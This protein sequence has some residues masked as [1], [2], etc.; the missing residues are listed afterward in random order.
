MNIIRAK[1]SSRLV[2]S[3]AILVF[4]VL[5]VRVF[6]H[7]NSR[8]WAAY[9]REF[10]KLSEQKLL[11]QIAA[12]AQAGDSAET[13][14]WEKQLREARSM[15]PHLRQVFLPDANVRDLC[16]SCHLGIDNPLFADAPE[17]FKAHPGKMLDLH[18][19]D[20]FGC[21]V[22]HHGQGVGT[23]AFAAHGYEETWYNPLIPHQ[24]L[25]APCIGCHET[26]YGLEGAEQFE[27]G[28]LAFQKYGCY[29]C[30]SA[31]GFEDLPKF[32]PILDG[33]KEKL[34]D[35]RWMLSWL[36]TPEKMR[37]RTLM[38]TFTLSDD[39]IRDIAAYALSLK[40]DKEYP[41]VDLSPAS[42]KEGETLFTDLGCKACH[43][44]KREEDSLT[45]RIPNLSDAGI[46][47]NGNWV[48]EYLKDPKAYNPDTRMPKLDITDSDRL[49][50]TA[51]L[52]TLKDNAEL[53]RS[54][55][56]KTDGASVEN[57]GKLVQ[58]Q[59][60]YGCHKMKD[61]DRSPLPGVEVAE[62]AKKTLDELP[63]GN[64]QVPT[65][66]W[67]WILNK[68][69]EPK[70]YE[71]V[72]MPLKMPKFNFEEGE[73]E[74]LTIFY[75][76]NTV[77][78]L[79]Q[80]YMLAAAEAQRRG[81]AGEW[82]VTENHCRGCHMFEENV[83]PRID[84]FIGLKTYVPPRLV[85]EG[86]KVQPQWAFQY[87][88][89]PVPMRPWLKM[90]MPTF[91]F[92]Y[93][94]VQDMIDYFSVKSSSAEDARVP[95]VLIPQKEEMPQLDRDMG[96]YRVVA[97]KCMQCHPISLE[98]GLP[99]DVKLEDLSINLMLSKTRL[100]F[101]WIKNFLRNPDKYAGAGTK[102]PYV[103]YTPEGAQRV[104]DAEMW[105]D[106][107]SKYLMI[108][109]KIPE[110]PPEAEEEQKEEIDWTQMDY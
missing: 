2:F 107:V 3:A 72:D 66:K 32:A 92:S 79:P 99:E 23:T 40:S 82:E 33:F 94:Q 91:S 41:K 102:M 46:K 83:K 89:K 16:T 49:N 105:I 74:S 42:A 29:D 109:D 4:A 108:M 26:S 57:G 85:G 48:F 61:F 73:I 76:S 63:F 11:E 13:E 59:G 39:E 101:E 110:K 7:E 15:R 78:Q 9:Q 55:P 14:K 81:Q 1:F 93:E 62:V 44:E 12:S 28:R 50:L 53:V 80:K 25:Q 65:T 106:L 30:H 84:Q 70:I 10:Q 38:P 45:R 56:L 58:L 6:Q 22:C 60:C 103:Y 8:E 97:D 87:L 96:E 17:P 5:T 36:K 69:K 52:M 86:E 37:P 77:F 104:S 100:R 20:K 98:G 75:F 54:E 64:S 67:D 31:R 19:A 95:Y 51:Y 24:Y 34:A 18:K 71:T 47:L 68:I 88:T 43:S 35:E 21:T 27:L 90:R